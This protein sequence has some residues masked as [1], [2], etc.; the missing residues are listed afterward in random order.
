MVSVEHSLKSACQGS[1][2]DFVMS[3]GCSP[4]KKSLSW[5]KRC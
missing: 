5:L 3:P 4:T 2:I 1:A